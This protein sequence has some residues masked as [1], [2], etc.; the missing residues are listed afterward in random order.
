[1]AYDFMVQ[2]LGFP[3]IC[4]FESR[5][6]LTQHQAWQEKVVASYVN[7]VLPNAKL[8]PPAD[9]VSTGWPIGSSLLHEMFHTL[10]LLPPLF[11]V[12]FLWAGVS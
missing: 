6:L 7:S 10:P 5:I 8:T 2:G 12:Q 4:F 9:Q 11:P 1:M 3:S